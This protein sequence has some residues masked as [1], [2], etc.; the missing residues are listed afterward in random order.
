VNIKTRNV[1]L[2]VYPRADSTFPSQLIDVLR[3]RTMFSIQEESYVPDRSTYT[4]P[5][6]ETSISSMLPQD[7]QGDWLGSE[8]QGAQAVQSC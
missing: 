2:M 4:G 3:V 7:L 1:L 6:N 5:V 8:N